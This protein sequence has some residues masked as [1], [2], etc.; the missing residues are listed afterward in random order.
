[1][2]L[3]RISI[4]SFL[5]SVTVL[6]SVWSCG[7]AAFDV[8]YIWTNRTNCGRRVA[9]WFVA[10]DL[11]ITTVTYIATF[12]SWVVSFTIGN[13]LQSCS[14]NP[15]VRYD[16]FAGLVFIA[17]CIISSVLVYSNYSALRSQHLVVESH[18]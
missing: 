9:G 2:T 15:C 8:C 13:R 6:Q 7:M 11:F 5:L 12:G 17:G 4:T 1:M 10:I 18:D 3:L 14:I 16:I